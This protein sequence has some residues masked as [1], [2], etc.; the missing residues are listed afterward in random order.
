MASASVVLSLL[1][2]LFRDFV[3]VTLHN[4]W[5][6]LTRK[7]PVIALRD[8]SVAAKSARPSRMGVTNAGRGAGGAYTPQRSKL[9]LSSKSRFE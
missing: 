1:Q 4:P 3:P 2:P 7:W 6:S 5:H 8:W 9:P